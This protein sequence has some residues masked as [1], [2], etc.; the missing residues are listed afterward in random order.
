VIPVDRED[1]KQIYYLNK[2]VR[3]WQKELTR[4]QCQSFV[5]GQEITGMPFAGGTSD[6]T[7]DLATEMREVE[8]IIRGKLAEIQVQ[9]R[10]II[11]YIDSVPDSIVRQIIFYRNVSCMSWRSVAMELGG[12]NS[13]DGVRMQ[14]NRFFKKK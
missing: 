11:E 3:M 7:G 1:L 14:Y 10:K 12:D 13:E 6:R 5:K 2:E 4:L 9:R 8:D